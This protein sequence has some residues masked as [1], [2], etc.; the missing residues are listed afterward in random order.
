M[1]RSSYFYISI[2]LSAVCW[3]IWLSGDWADIA[4][5]VLPNLT[6]FSIAA[7]AILFSILSKDQIELLRTPAASLNDRSPLLVLASTIGHAVVVQASA[8]LIAICYRPSSYSEVAAWFTTRRKLVEQILKI[9]DI[10]IS[11]LGLFFCIYSIILVVAAVTTIF[12]L[13]EIVN[14]GK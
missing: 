5:A 1:L 11:S 2:V 6:G 8:I 14:K 7:F 12:R 9:V 3:P 4:Q 10:G 13:L